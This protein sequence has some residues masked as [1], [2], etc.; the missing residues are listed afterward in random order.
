VA[1]VEE[2]EG[3]ENLDAVWAPDTPPDGTVTWYEPGTTLVWSV[4]VHSTQRNDT[5]P[6]PLDVAKDGLGGEMGPFVSISRGAFVGDVEPGRPFYWR[7]NPND[8]PLAKVREK[9]YY[10]EFGAKLNTDITNDL[11]GAADHPFPSSFRFQQENLSIAYVRDENGNAFVNKT[12]ITYRL[13]APA[14]LGDELTNVPNPSRTI[15]VRAGQ[16][17]TK[18]PNPIDG[19]SKVRCFTIVFNV[20]PKVST[21][22]FG[23]R[24]LTRLLPDQDQCGSR[25]LTPVSFTGDRCDSISAFS[26][27]VPVGM[28]QEVKVNVYF[29]DFNT[30]FLDNCKT[31]DDV[32]IA[33][34]SNPGI[35]NSAT[36]SMTL[37]GNDTA[38]G[39]MA[40]QKVAV[41]YGL[42]GEEEQTPAIYYLSSRTITFR[43]DSSDLGMGENGIRYEVCFEGKSKMSRGHSMASITSAPVCGF[44]QVL[45][46]RPQM[47][48]S[49]MVLPVAGT[50]QL[51]LM[52]QNTDTYVTR[53]EM[54]SLPLDVTV[55]CRYTWNIIT[56]D[57]NNDD[58]GANVF[59]S[60]DRA[61]YLR[62]H[63]SAMVMED[64]MNPLPPGATISHPQMMQTFETSQTLTWTPLRGSEG[65]DF[66]FCLKVVENRTGIVGQTVCTTLRVKKCEVCTEAGD[67]LLS[68]AREYQTDWL[69]LWGA[70][71]TV[72]TP[73]QLEEYRPLM[74][75]PRFVT[76]RPEAVSIL[77]SR[78]KME[79]D[80]FMAM[81][82]DFRGMTHI[83]T[84]SESCTIPRICE[85][86]TT[87]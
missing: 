46:P 43:P 81:N 31:C 73:N 55:R 66:S 42:T 33:V 20:K 10:H 85:G 8:D 7:A 45:K 65:S 53:N 51:P 24:T 58:D 15:C 28:F 16:T 36:V 38:T 87:L 3:L 79:L 74:L 52:L 14:S 64:P 35:P 21:C 22:C 83:P 26:S 71:P 56:K 78:F 75:G 30:D 80:E 70:N 4:E 60:A 57:A 61:G 39:T 2:S 72:D 50:T 44:L 40:S 63:Y 49:T 62:G 29:E 18:Q 13:H 69:Q 1:G 47:V 23:R 34:L 27:G 9:F 25:T 76:N 17:F 54:E 12:R 5:I 86:S 32:E 48:S 37:G 82:P 67:T 68:V 84:S 77:A 41:T 11:I 59:D 19:D 6:F